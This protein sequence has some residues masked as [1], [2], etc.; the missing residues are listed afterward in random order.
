MKTALMASASAL[1]LATTNIS[2]A[3]YEKFV[4]ELVEQTGIVM[5]PYLSGVPPAVKNEAGVPM[6]PYLPWVPEAQEVV[7]GLST[8]EQESYLS[9]DRF[10][11]ELELEENR[12]N[13]ASTDQSL[14]SGP[15]DFVL[16]V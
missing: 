16:N 11:N 2:H 9:E 6:N 7:A 3:Q 15:I 14:G 8:L 13:P 12:L 5:N 10:P 1:L 4:N